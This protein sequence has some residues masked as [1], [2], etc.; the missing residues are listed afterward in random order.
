MRTW[1]ALVNW[2]KEEA[3]L[4]KARELAERE[5]RSWEEHYR[6]ELTGSPPRQTG[7][8]ACHLMTAGLPL[9]GAVPEFIARSDRR[10]RHVSA[11]KT[12]AV[13]S[14]VLLAVLASAMGWEASREASEAQYEAAGARRAQLRAE[15]E[16]RTAGAT[17]EFLSTIFDAPTP[18][19][20]LGRLITA[21]EL[22]RRRAAF[23]AAL[24]VRRRMLKAAHG[25]AL[26][27]RTASLVSTDRARPPALSER[28]TVLGA[29]RRHCAP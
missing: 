24:A 15:T 4:L 27:R 18:E 5:C 13:A 26:E 22:R 7:T 10:L 14:I 20:S 8:V 1:P 29:Y 23:N 3:S 21:R 28:R 11:L 2:L 17:V 19:N 12:I 6:F 16:A 9:P 25:A